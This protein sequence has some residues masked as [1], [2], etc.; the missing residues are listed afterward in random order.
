MRALTHLPSRSNR[1]A[2]LLAASCLLSGQ[3]ALA[4]TVA[5]PSY[6]PEEVVV[7]DSFQVTG[8]AE[9][10]AYAADSSLAATRTRAPLVDTPQAITVVTRDLINDQA[11]RSVADLTRYVP[12]VGIGQGEGN[13]DTPVMRGNSTTADFFIDGIRDD[14]QYYRDFYNI[15]RV[16]V[17]KGPNAM[18]FGRGGSGGVI[19]RV[20]KRAS[21]KPTNELSLSAGSWDQY[22][23]TLDAGH[24]L[25]ATAAL[26]LNV[27]HESARSYREAVDLKRTGINPAAAFFLSPTTQLHVSYEYFRDERVADRG[28]SSF[29]GVP[30]QTDASTFFG[31]PDQSTSEAT[32]H[33]VNATLE[34]RFGN[35]IVL[36]NSSRFGSYEKFYQNI[37]PGAVNAAGTAV[38]ISA[39]NN[40]NARDNWYNQTDL[41]VPF[42]TGPM[43]H[44][45]LVGAEAGLQENDNVRLTG[46]FPAGSG[47]TTTLTVPL[48]ATRTRVPAT[49]KPAASDADNTT[50]ATTLAAYVQDQVKL[51]SWL[52]AIAGVRVER[53]RAVLDNRRN[54]SRIQ[55]VDTPVSPRA[56]LVVKAA[57]DLSFYA[58]HSVS[59]LPRAGEQ[60]SS[61]TASNGS[62]AP[63][64][65]RNYEVGAKWDARSDLAFTAALYRLKR[66]NVAVADPA[67]PTRLI[68]VNGQEATGLELGFAGRVTPRW[69]IA[70]GYALQ[71][72]EIK[73]TQSAT[74]VRGNRLAQLPRHT[75]SWWNRFEV[76]RDFGIGL[77]TIYRDALFPSTDNR[78]RVPGFVRWDAALFYRVNDHLRAQL[79]VENVLDREY[80]ASAHSNTNILPG[81]PRAFRVTMTTAW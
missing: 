6:L 29:N 52:Q 66:G 65:F 60:L 47:Q 20:T 59:F 57:A 5:G 68:L 15:D 74:V 67:D 61:L 50:D 8:T 35:G 11:M 78:V 80:Y 30:L 62:L 69:S 19:N 27:L 17:L 33:G 41:L 28:V 1:A 23:A 37:Y 72:G 64:K 16:E 10:S 24:A 3:A 21:L 25:S 79:N 81:S 18:I 48:T 73:T 55:S 31:D 56:G 38:S 53:F 40:A 75:F 7:L 32:A 45:L 46:Y 36:R 77:G 63:E 39:Y 58:S 70:G 71:E 34:H 13:R 44:E 76:T 42:E 43:R 51:T 49:F 22:R 14:V 9:A 12:G 26:R 4:A 54:G 2:T